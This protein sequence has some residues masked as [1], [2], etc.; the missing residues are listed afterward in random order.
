MDD[1][2]LDQLLRTADPASRNYAIDDL[3]DD[4]VRARP[5]P[6]RRRRWRPV[7]IA[8]G[9]IFAMAGLLAFTDLDTYLLTV[10][11]FS[12][13]SPGTVRTTDGLP[14][15]EVAGTDKGEECAIWLDLGGLTDEQFSEV[16]EYWSHADATDFAAG[17]AARMETLPADEHPEVF[18]KKDQILED[19][20]RIVPGIT[21]GTTAPGQFFADNEPHLTSIFT[22]CGDELKSDK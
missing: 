4:V 2:Q 10:P 5:V 9:A 21:W 14:Y 16:D 19:L 3:V 11:P 7:L 8:G 17:V 18:A 20:A 13:L 6:V 15:V 1:R 22:V 12:A